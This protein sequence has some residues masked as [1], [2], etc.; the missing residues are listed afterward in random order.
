MNADPIQSREHILISKIVLHAWE[1]GRTLDLPELIRQIQKP[2]ISTV[3]AYSLETF[4]PAKDRVKFA[5]TLNNVLASPS[6][7]T[8][9]KGDPLDLA[10]MLYREGRPQQLIFYIAHLRD[11]ERMFFTTLLLEEVLSWTRQQ[12][13]TTNLRGLLY[14]DEVFGYLPPHR[15]IRRASGR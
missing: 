7:A 10:N 14:F 8:W 12:S 1:E 4:F 5:S 6:F 13:G 15:R 11:T 3:G 9:M 2:P